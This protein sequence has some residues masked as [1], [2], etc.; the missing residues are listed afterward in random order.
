MLCPS[1]KPRV[2]L[3]RLATPPDLS[4][5]PNLLSS[6]LYRNRKSFLSCLL[7]SC[8]PFYGVRSLFSPSFSQGPHPGWGGVIWELQP[9]PPFPHFW[10]LVLEYTVLLLIVYLVIM[11]KRKGK[12]EGCRKL[13]EMLKMGKIMS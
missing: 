11:L 9:P 2:W 1:A 13:F 7:R 3:A 12:V 4:N 5:V 6:T 8:F 10:N